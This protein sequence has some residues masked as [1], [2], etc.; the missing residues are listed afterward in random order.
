MSARSMSARALLALCAIFTALAAW[1]LSAQDARETTVQGAARDWLAVIDRADYV[2]SWNAAGSKFRLAITPERWSEAVAGVRGPLG[3][4]VQRSVLKTTFTH[5]FPGVP[6]GDYALVVFR[7]AFEKKSEGD[8]TVTLEHEA[9]G[10]WRVIG[11]F[12]R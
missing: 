3:P 1:P 4:V 2:A 12:I 5:S 11:Y 6:D 10:K 9:D 8:E 7:T